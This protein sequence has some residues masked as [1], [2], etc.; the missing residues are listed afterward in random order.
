MIQQFYRVHFFHA[1]IMRNSYILHLIV[2]FVSPLFPSM[3]SERLS[4]PVRLQRLY[5]QLVFSHC[6]LVN[7]QYRFIM[8]SAD[9]NDHFLQQKICGHRY[10]LHTSLYDTLHLW[11]LNLPIITI[12]TSIAPCIV[13]NCIFEII[14]QCFQLPIIAC[15]LSS[16][17]HMFK[18]IQ[19]IFPS[20]I[21]LHL[22]QMH[23]VL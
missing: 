14:Q 22:C 7:D 3:T 20:I 15:A 9:P 11:N 10:T 17:E 18:L 2:A 23:A 16:V 13:V 19:Q 21:R 5:P 4:Y 1:N 8:A 6:K 12:Y